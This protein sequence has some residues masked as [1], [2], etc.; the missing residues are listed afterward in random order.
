MVSK[1]GMV[2]SFDNLSE[3]KTLF[4]K[5]KMIWMVYVFCSFTFLRKHDVS[6]FGNLL[7]L[8]QVKESFDKFQIKII[9]FR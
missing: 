3:K 7:V 5:R 8:F 1:L 2:T 4:S 6:P 9:L